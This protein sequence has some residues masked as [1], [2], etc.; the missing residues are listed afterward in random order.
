MVAYFS[1]SK[2]LTTCAGREEQNRMEWKSWAAL[3]L[4]SNNCIADEI[5]WEYF[6]RT[7]TAHHSTRQAVLFVMTGF[8]MRV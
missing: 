3:L 1:S 2:D 6:G 8:G 7:R 4:L 5:P